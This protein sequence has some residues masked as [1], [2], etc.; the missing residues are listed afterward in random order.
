MRPL[1]PS[2][3][4]IDKSEPSIEII[5]VAEGQFFSIDLAPTITIS[6]PNLDTSSIE[7]NGVP[8]ISGTLISTEGTYILVAAASDIAGNSVST[9]VNFVIDKT[10]PT[11]D[12]TAYP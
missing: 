2:D 9:T 5:G 7:L 10:P 1:Y 6:D 4:I 8:Y 12:V 3:F 11:I